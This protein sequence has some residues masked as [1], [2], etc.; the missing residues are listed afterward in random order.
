MAG[1]LIVVAGAVA[2]IAAGVSAASA[3]S[4]NDR[5]KFEF[6]SSADQ[7]HIGTDLHS[8]HYTDFNHTTHYYLRG[9]TDNPRDNA[10]CSEQ[11]IVGENGRPIKR[12]TCIGKPSSPLGQ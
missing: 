9:Y 7:L 10:S 12:V 11:M 6:Y 5:F 1:R 2:A 3:Q 8:N 4:I